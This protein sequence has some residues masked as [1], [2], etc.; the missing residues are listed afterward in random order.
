MPWIDDLLARVED[1]QVDLDGVLRAIVDHTTGLLG[2]ERGTFYLV[3]HARR[4]L[5]SR[6]G[7]LPEIREIRLGLGEGVAGWVAANGRSLYAA[8]DDPRFAGRVDAATGYQTRELLAAPV[9]DRGGDVIGVL[10]VLNPVRGPFG[11]AERRTLEKL[12]GEVGTALAHTSLRA[13]LHRATRQPLAFRFNF[14][15]GDAPAMLE[16]YSRVER[17]ARTDATVLIRG[18]TGTGKGLIARAVHFNSSRANGPFVKVDCAALPAQ[19]IE[20]ELFGH[21][22]GAYTGAD[23]ESEGRVAGAEGGTLFL[24]EIGELAPQVQAKLLQL[25]QDRTYHRVGEARPRTANVRFVCATHR[26]LEEQVVAGRFRA[27]LYYRLRVVP[28]QLPPLRARGHGDIDRLVDHFL[29]EFAQRHG[30][31]DVRLDD[32]AR[33]ALHAHP[34]PGNVREL[35]HCIESAVVLAPAPMI[36]VADLPLGP[37]RD[38]ATFTAGLT[39]LREVEAAYLRWVLERSD[40]NRSEA[41]RV[42]GIGRNTLARR[43]KEG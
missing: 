2:A 19:L 16:V 32:A 23:R 3:D 37:A 33:A 43:L 20:N 42:L 7:H 36:Q 35:E 8:K 29:F 39:T 11:A 13:Q 22:K 17:A 14:V 1:R 15:V 5:V 6:V 24:D 18:E 12:G 9:R 10:Q 31:P 26:D 41:A 4:E 40:G 34:W 27:D 38:G 28:L 25:V 21:A 30:R